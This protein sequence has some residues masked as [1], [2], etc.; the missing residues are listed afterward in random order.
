M[1]AYVSFFRDNLS[2]IIFLS[3]YAHRA[4]YKPKGYAGDYEMMN[5]V[6]SRDLRGTTLFA[7]CMQ[8]YFVDEPA[9]RAVRNREEYIRGKIRN[10]TKD[11]AGQAK[12]R[13]LSVASGPAKE[14]QN[15]VR[16]YQGDLANIEFHLL[17]QDLD[18]LKHAQRKVQEVAIEMKKKVSLQLHH[19]TIKSVIA[20]GL[21][22]K[23]FDFIYSAG[24]FDYFTEPVAVF[25][26]RQLFRGLTPSGTLIIGNF[27]LNNPNQFAMGLIM[28]WDLIYRSGEQLAKM[29]SGIGR[30]VVI[31]EEEQSINLFAIIRG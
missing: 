23:D 6:Y 4:Y 21:R 28:D 14:V 10:L 15:F 7:K 8:R 20:E 17:D 5:H 27:S 2:E 12:I 13:I 1:Q 25:A 9:G 26:A 11:L 30:S 3:S 18:A 24:L 29:F 19:K 16:E 31:E 22:L